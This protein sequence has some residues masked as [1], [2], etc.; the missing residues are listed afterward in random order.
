MAQGIIKLN[1]SPMSREKGTNYEESQFYID[2][3]AI[4]EMVPSA[5]CWENKSCN[6]IHGNV[7]NMIANGSIFPSV[8]EIALSILSALQVVKC[9]RLGLN[10]T[11]SLRSTK[12]KLHNAPLVCTF[13]LQAL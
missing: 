7:R 8:C 6:I 11:T 5:H 3:G 10:G 13:K 12:M 2:C 4:I 9:H 1:T